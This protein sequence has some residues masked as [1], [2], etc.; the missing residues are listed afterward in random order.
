MQEYKLEFT[1]LPSG[2]GGAGG[3]LTSLYFPRVTLDTE[4]SDNLSAASTASPEGISAKILFLDIETSPN[5]AYVW[6]L[7]DQQINHQAIVIPQEMIC[8]SAKWLGDDSIEFYSVFHH[9]K[10][11]MIAEVHRLLDEADIIVHY[12]GKKYD[13]PHINR[14][15]ILQ[16]LKPPSPY[17]QIDL[18]H[19]IRRQFNFSSGKLDYVTKALDLPSKA[20][21]GGYQMWKDCINS[22]PDAWG[23][24]RKYNEQDTRILETLYLRILPWIPQHPSMVAYAQRISCPACGSERLQRRGFSYTTVSKYQRFQCQACGKWCRGS[25]KLSGTEI[26][27]VSIC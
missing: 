16:G 8:F 6:G 19:T 5:L 11:R 27:E 25:K 26:R 4:R 23:L 7:F 21:S 17:R 20:E 1:A 14:E 3:D 10:K 18:Y 15:I 22:D 12:N 13:I 24:M 9:N 2:S